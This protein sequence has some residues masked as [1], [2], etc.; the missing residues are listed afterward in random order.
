MVN[1][2]SARMTAWAEGRT[3]E[4]LGACWL[5]G[6][7]RFSALLLLSACS[8]DSPRI[9]PLAPEAVILAF[10]D[11]LT[12]G[13]GANVGQDYPSHLSRMTG[14]RVT[15]AGVPAEI[16]SEATTRLAAL[17]AETSPDLLVLIHGGNDLLRKI[18]PQLTAGN[19][20]AMI[21]LARGSG[22]SVV[23]LGVPKPAVFGLSSADLY[24]DVATANKTAIDL[25]AIPE[26][27]GNNALKSDLVHPNNEGYRQLAIAVAQLLRQT[28]A[29]N[30]TPVH[31]P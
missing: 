30:G 16:T 26:I 17:L 8:P 13:V 19:L 5:R 28:G 6:A 15:N 9:A 7:F 27:L 3:R 1:R 18:D 22:I 29:W 25:E 14:F 31:S 4:L 20:T 24:R 11:S 21:Q 10:G 2:I 12:S 23:M